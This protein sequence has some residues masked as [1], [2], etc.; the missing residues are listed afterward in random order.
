[1]RGCEGARCDGATCEGLSDN[2]SVHA[3]FYA[4]GAERDGDVVDLPH[5]EAQHLVRVLR[6]TA[7]TAIRVFNGRGGEFDAVVDTATKAGVQV[8]VHGRRDS[9]AEVGVDVTL[10]QAVLKG[11]KMDEVVRD[12]VMMGVL[13]IRPIV[14]TRSEITL[15][16]LRRGRRQERWQR[17]SVSSAKQCGRAVVPAVHEPCTF[18]EALGPLGATGS[19]GCGLMLVEPSAAANVLS[20]GDVGEKPSSATILVGPEGGWTPEEITLGS[21]VC[22]PVTLGSRTLRADA[23]G[24]VAVTALLTHWREL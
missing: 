3:R 23:M 16:S 19:T 1:M 10:A 2:R 6:L 20:V 5:E 18:E 11:D 13:A 22:R 17:I 9:Q 14:T 15:A 7:G 24:L 12:A 8:R 21:S 4:P